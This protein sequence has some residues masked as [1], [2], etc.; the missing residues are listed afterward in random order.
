[1]HFTDRML[2]IKNDFIA[3]FFQMENKKWFT[4]VELIMA[5]IIA[6]TLIG[7]A[8]SIYT[9]LQ[10]Q[11]IRRSNKRLVVAES[12]DLIDKIH[13]AVLYYTIDYEEYFNRR[14]LW[15]GPWNTW[16]ST[17][18]NEWERYYCWTGAAISDEYNWYNIYQRENETWWCFS[19]WNQKYWEYQFQHRSL[20]TWDLNNKANSWSNMKMWPI[21][22]SPNTWRDYLFLISPEWDERYYFRRVFKTWDNSTWKNNNLYTIQMLKLKWFDAWTWHDF[23]SWWAYDWFIDTWACDFSQWFSCYW[24]EVTRGFDIPW[25]WDDWWVDIT[26]DRVTVNDFRVDIYPPKDP[27]L[28]GNET[29]YV[30][31]PYIKISLTMNVYGKA[32]NDELTLSTTY[33]LKNSYTRFPITQYTWYIPEDVQE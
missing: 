21:A 5:L 11:D 10:W 26:T 3:I 9:G 33:S 12:N 16:F 19:W 7:I 25:S 31:D 1:M 15:Y 32:T 6:G 4:L 22:I 30:E 23:N 29:W 24:W 27:Y 13:E 2:I 20:V 14:W 8:M 18:G 17:Y 28:V